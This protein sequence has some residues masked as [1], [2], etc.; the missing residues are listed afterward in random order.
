MGQRKRTGQPLVDEAILSVEDRVFSLE[1]TPLLD[2][3]LIEDVE[4]E[5]GVAT[6]VRHGL[7]RVWRGYVI[8]KMAGASTAG[9]LQHN[10]PTT[11]QFYDRKQIIKLTAAGWGATITV[12][13][14]VF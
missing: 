5:M 1:K 4:L 7:G 6:M 14:Y 8:T 2:G 10:D 11:A 9:V 3:R 12:D 13:L